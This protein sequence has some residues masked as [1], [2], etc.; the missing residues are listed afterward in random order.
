M[1][2][3]LLYNEDAGSGVT[4]D[5]IRTALER[6]GHTL[7]RVVEKAGDAAALL[8]G[9]VELAVAAGGDGTVAAAAR[10]VAGSGIPLA[11]LPLG[12]AN[13]IARS[14]GAARSIES[15]IEGWEHA[16]RR[17]LDLG[18]ACGPWGERRFVEGV[19][20][21]LVP[22]AIAAVDAWPLADDAGTNAKLAV[23]LRR[24]RETVLSLR[25]SRWTLVLDGVETAGDFLLVEVQN[26]PFVGATL[27][28]AQDATPSDGMLS[29]VVATE[30]QRGELVHYLE[31]RID[32]HDVCLAVASRRAAH[33]EL[34]GDGDLHVDDE[35]VAGRGG[36][37]VSIRI[38]PG[39]VVVLGPVSDAADADRPPV[40]DCGA[41]LTA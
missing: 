14:L 29:V 7:L 20:G 37:R 17:P 33:V 25:P 28:L 36:G 11:I 27:R 5:E 30:A 26:I 9:P 32:G 10:A 39:A 38:E 8:G 13:N 2:L 24:Y 22:A 35:L 3:A 16:P 12:T 1:K 15:L 31:R 6:R 34:E 19:G 21:G 41:E 40:V 4:L 23:A 18:R